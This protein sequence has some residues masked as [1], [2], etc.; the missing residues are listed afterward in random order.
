MVSDTLA[1]RRKTLAARGVDVVLSVELDRLP[2]EGTGTPPVDALPRCA[3]CRRQPARLSVVLE[4]TPADDES[5]VDSLGEVEV[6][7]CGRCAETTAPGVLAALDLK[8][9][10]RTVAAPLLR[11]LGCDNVLV[12]T[13]QF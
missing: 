5:D 2:A 12:D 11:R 9:D 6:A 8:T 7:L 13:A 3:W 4:L 10:V 1:Q